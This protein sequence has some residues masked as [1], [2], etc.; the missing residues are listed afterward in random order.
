[1]LGRISFS[2][3]AASLA[4]L[5]G[6]VAVE[7]PGTGKTPAPT[8]VTELVRPPYQIVLRSRSGEVVPE[9]NQNGQTGSGY[10]DV[11]QRD[12][13]T[14]LAIMRGAVVAGAETHKPGQAALRFILDQ[15]F[16]ITPSRDGL[17][18]PQLMVTSMLTGILDST[19]PVGGT[20]Q[21]GPACFAILSGGQPLFSNCIKP[22]VVGTCQNVFIS[23]RQGTFE[24]P[25]VAGSYCLHQTFEMS[26]S[27]PPIETLCPR[28]V[29]AA[30]AVFS[31]DPR[32]DNRWNYVFEP[33][34]AVP[35]QNF[36]F[37]VL[38]RV[39]EQPRAPAEL[40]PPPLP[41]PRKMETTSLPS[42][43]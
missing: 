40:I 27:A 32:L 19:Q 17:L 3:L 39:V 41:L 16:D 33:Y 21:Q 6:L 12:P 5:P 23:E 13:A 18:P 35:H 31:V 42:A 20:A 2:L 24:L 25:A 11:V 15:Q 30:G 4:C 1:M 37:G 22:H 28:V 9:R 7:P 34:R 8:H 26:A 10:V 29:P 43:L 14:I 36:G 38:L